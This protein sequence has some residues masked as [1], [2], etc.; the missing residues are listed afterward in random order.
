M[1]PDR[2]HVRTALKHVPS[3]QSISLIEGAQTTKPTPVR[4]QALFV[5]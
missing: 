3:P 1:C 5:A 2:P 4:R